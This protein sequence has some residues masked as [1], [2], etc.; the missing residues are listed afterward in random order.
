MGP[1]PSSSSFVLINKGSK[2]IQWKMCKVN[3]RLFKIFSFNF[4]KIIFL[5]YHVFYRAP[6]ASIKTIYTVGVGGSGGLEVPP[7]GQGQ[8][9]GEQE[10]GGHHHR[11][12]GQGGHLLVGWGHP[13]LISE[14]VNVSSHQT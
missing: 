6:V 5:V 3:S 2:I 12:Q 9:E 11:H 8:Q 10:A 13:L 4:F 1:T 14:M 7:A